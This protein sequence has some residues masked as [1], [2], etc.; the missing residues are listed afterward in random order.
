MLLFTLKF[1]GVGTE[2]IVLHICPLFP[3]EKV[4]FISYC[5]IFEIDIVLHLFGKYVAYMLFALV[6]F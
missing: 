2:D 1:K 4:A 6:F 5:R 3:P